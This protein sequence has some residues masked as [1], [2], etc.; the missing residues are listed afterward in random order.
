MEV[1]EFAEKISIVNSLVPI[2]LHR[3]LKDEDIALSGSHVLIL[4]S[5]LEHVVKESSENLVFGGL[6]EQEGVLELI[7]IRLALA[8]KL[9]DIEAVSGTSVQQLRHSYLRVVR[10]SLPDLAKF[11][12][13]HNGRRRHVR[14]VVIKVFIGHL[15]TFDFS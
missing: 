5:L 13:T 9:I 15:R 2:N 12:I 10:Q 6:D 11:F 1:F 4:W 14:N 7:L 3:G 8:V